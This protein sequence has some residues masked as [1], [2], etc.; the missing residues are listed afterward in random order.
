MFRRAVTALCHT[1]ARALLALR[2]HVHR[3]LPSVRTAPLLGFNLDSR[4]S[5]TMTWPFSSF[6]PHDYSL[7][8]PSWS[9]EMMRLYDHY[10]SL[11]EQ[12]GGGKSKA[13][14]VRMP[15]YNRLLKYAKGGQCLSKMVQAKARLFTRNMKEEGASF[16]YVVFLNKQEKMCTCIFQ[17]GHLLEGPP[18]Y[19][20]GGAIATIIDTVA[21][22]LTTYLGGL[23]MTAN[24]TIN[25]RSPIPLGSVVLVHSLLEKM[26]E[27][28]ILIFCQVTSSDGSKLHTEATGLF[29]SISLGHL[30]GG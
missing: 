17:A 8:N 26:E 3:H 5:V 4:W 29:L 25:Y 22:A 10:N 13:P 18:G 15:S 27:R 2:P 30:I 7:P 6:Q 23:V 1:A 19:V 28:K 11:C 12:E 9:P 14:W 20:H 16:E 24:L 21:G